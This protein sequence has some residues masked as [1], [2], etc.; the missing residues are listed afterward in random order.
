MPSIRVCL[1]RSLRLARLA[2]AMPSISSKLL[3]VQATMSRRCPDGGTPLD[4]AMLCWTVPWSDAGAIAM[5][6]WITV[7]L[8]PATGVPGCLVFLG[9]CGE[10][11]NFAQEGTYAHRGRKVSAEPTQPLRRLLRPTMLILVLE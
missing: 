10:A 3:E 2:M 7:V 6:P 1:V 11:W 5:P 8:G 9:G 4:L